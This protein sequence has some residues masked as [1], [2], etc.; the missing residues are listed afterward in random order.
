[1]SAPQE[2]PTAMRE[3]RHLIV[4]AD[5]FGLTSGVN[6]GIIEAYENGIVTSASLMVRYDAARKAAEYARSHPD[7]SI[8]LHFELGEW[9]YSSGEWVLAYQVVDA[10]DASAVEG[11]L[12][13]QLEIFEQ[14]MG[15][16]PT[17]LDSHQ[18]VHQSEPARSIALAAARRMG[19]P[20]RAC[21][22][23]IRY[24]GEFYGQTGQGDPYPDGISIGGLIA[25]I[26]RLPVGWT[27]LGCHPGYS[28]GLDSVYGREREEE[29]RVLCDPAIAHA[30]ADSG[31]QLWSFADLPHAR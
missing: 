1:M 20:L 16:A 21:D 6:R 30:L 9:R 14:L 15:R 22:E 10:E 8:G 23:R 2:E 7:F 27:E 26:D 28:D 13:R 29:V 11:E 12:R 24:A 31:V 25:V 19:V 5:D 4:N 17:H 3:A 18:H